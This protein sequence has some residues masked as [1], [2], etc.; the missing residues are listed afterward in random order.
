MGLC[1]SKQTLSALVSLV[2][3]NSLF[4]YEVCFFLIKPDKALS[5][6]LRYIK[7]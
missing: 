1:V 3:Q 7:H 4:V 5:Y 2:E 6:A